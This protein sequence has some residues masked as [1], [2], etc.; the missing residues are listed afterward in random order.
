MLFVVVCGRCLLIVDYCLLCVVCSS[1]FVVYGV[2]CRSLCVVRCSL[3]VACC[4]WLA[5]SVV[6]VVCCVVCVVVRCL[7][8]VVCC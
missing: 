3:R 6:L 7:L 5:C 4:L 8:C 1:F 2:C